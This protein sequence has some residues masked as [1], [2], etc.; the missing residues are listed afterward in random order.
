MAGLEAEVW[1]RVKS[2]QLNTRHAGHLGHPDMSEGIKRRPF[3]AL[4]FCESVKLPDITADYFHFPVQLSD[5][6]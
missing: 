3:P 6:A 5:T 2:K 4:L 1:T